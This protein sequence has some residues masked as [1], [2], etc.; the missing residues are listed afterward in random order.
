[1]SPCLAASTT[2]SASIPNGTTHTCDEST[3]AGRT[4]PPG[5]K[6]PN[7]EVERTSRRSEGDAQPSAAIAHFAM[8]MPNG[9]CTN[10]ARHAR[11][12]GARGAK[13]EVFLTRL[14]DDWK[15]TQSHQEIPDG[16]MSIRV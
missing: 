3:I 14:H 2:T 15:A 10:V 16:S 4:C 5:E 7:I 11:G 6:N 1:M 13:Q 8:Q 9:F 12:R